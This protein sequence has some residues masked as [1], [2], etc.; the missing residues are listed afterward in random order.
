[1]FLLVF[2]FKGESMQKGFNC[3]FTIYVRLHLRV[4]QCSERCVCVCDQVSLHF[5]RRKSR[6]ISKCRTQHL[7]IKPPRANVT[8]LSSW[9]L[10]SWLVGSV[11]ADRQ[12][13]PVSNSRENDFQELPR[14]YPVP[15]SLKS[16]HLQYSSCSPNLYLILLRQNK[17]KSW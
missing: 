4:T 12:S 8:R 16:E 5:F 3:Y 13:F 14:Q 10:F 9:H 7:I 11:A 15:C 2:L 1:M 17:T 6:Y